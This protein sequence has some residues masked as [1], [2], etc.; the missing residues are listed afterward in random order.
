MRIHSDTLS[1]MHIINTVNGLGTSVRVQGIIKHGSRSRA[2]AFDFALSGSGN[3]G[4]Q[5]GA[6]D[7]KAATW[8][9]WGMVLAELFKLDPNAIVPRV[10]ESAE[11]F[12]WTTG[13]RYRTLV[14]SDQ[15][16]RHNW[17]SDRDHSGWSA[18]GSYHVN[19]CKCGAIL[20]RMR[21][22]YT[23]SDSVAYEFDGVV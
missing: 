16:V 2:R 14:P 20:R 4:G 10:Y 9:E 1:A 5:W 8:D 13:D 19:A 12:H 6:L 11:H 15:H 17:L 21:P 18:G 3:Q 23:W 22:G 7:Y